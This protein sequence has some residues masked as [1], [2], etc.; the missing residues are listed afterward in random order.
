MGTLTIKVLQFK[1]TW[2]ELAK[3]FYHKNLPSFGYKT[4]IKDLTSPDTTRE[5]YLLSF[6]T[7]S[8]LKIYIY[9]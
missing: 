9:I 7:T 4:L 6:E 8:H 5:V 2:F 1:Y 3:W